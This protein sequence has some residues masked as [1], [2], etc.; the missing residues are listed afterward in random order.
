MRIQW[1]WS[2]RLAGALLV[3]LGGCTDNL[4]AL[5]HGGDFFH[6]LGISR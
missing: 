6:P 2:G 4:T 3:G 5:S 1:G